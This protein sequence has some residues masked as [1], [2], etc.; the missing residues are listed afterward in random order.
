MSGSLFYFSSEG[1]LNKIFSFFLF[2]GLIIFITGCAEKKE[3]GE[4][5]SG[6]TVKIGV[7]ASPEVLNPFT[8]FVSNSLEI[9]DIICRGFYDWNEEWKLI[10]RMALKVPSYDDKTIV[11]SSAGVLN[12]TIPLAPD[13]R[14]SN[15]LYVSAQDFIFGNQVAMYPP[16]SSLNSGWINSISKLQSYEEYML[17]MSIMSPGYGYM[18][19]FRP[20]PAF[21]LEDSFYQKPGKMITDPK[22]LSRISNGPYK[23]KDL[24]LSRDK[25]T[26][27]E[28]VRNPEYSRK[29]T[30]IA[31]VKFS[32]YEK[33]EFESALYSEAFDYAVRLTKEQAHVLS[34]KNDYNL[35]Y[36]PNT[37]M[38]VMYI[39]PATI[40]NTRLR[41]ALYS[42]IDRDSILKENLGPQG[43]VSESPLHLRHPYYISVFPNKKSD[44]A[45]LLKSAGAVFKNDKMYIENRPFKV[46]IAHRN[47][48]FCGKIYESIDVFLKNKGI[49]TLKMD[50][51]SVYDKKS[52]PD[53]VID[54]VNSSPWVTPAEIITPLKKNP[55]FNSFAL[56]PTVIKWDSEVNNDISIKY[57]SNFS[58][59]FRKDLFVKQQKL[60]ASEFVVIPLFSDLTVCAVRKNLHNV[61]PRGF[62]SET[63]N[64]ED[65]TMTEN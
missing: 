55:L 3:T 61:K 50:Y 25:I 21:V 51:A 29:K 35:L 8:S 17:E 7:M 2:L 62:G 46:K 14:W 10:P 6:K 65:W 26:K 4:T 39:N 40:K 32:L 5:L 54:I 11:K 60:L 41:H 23:V 31:V 37:L 20:L 64:I 45:A 33:N 44:S 15:G 57:F 49:E 18:Y 22:I 34:S 12:L 59:A 43:K 16:I 63:W 52:E 38:Y 56:T 28:L 48:G 1:A 36:T 13:A 27:V 9:E 42:L 53:I 30:D 58:D 19:K 47:S 24:S